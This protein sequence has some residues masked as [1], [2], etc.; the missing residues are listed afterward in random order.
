MFND[1]CRRKGDDDQHEGSFRYIVFILLRFLIFVTCSYFEKMRCK[2]SNMYLC[3][4]RELF[5]IRGAALI[6]QK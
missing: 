2:P 1:L 6:A 5:D 3:N 4:L